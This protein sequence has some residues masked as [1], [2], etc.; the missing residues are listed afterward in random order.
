M[1]L[2]LIK[3]YISHFLNV[4]FNYFKEQKCCYLTFEMLIYHLNVD[5][6]LRQNQP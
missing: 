5:E 3:V 2:K 1:L 4:E 6:L